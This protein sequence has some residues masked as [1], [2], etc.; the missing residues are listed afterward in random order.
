MNMIRKGQVCEVIKGDSISQR[1]LSPPR[2]AIHAIFI[3]H[4]LL[5]L[6]TVEI[7]TDLT[8]L[9]LYFNQINTLNAYICYHLKVGVCSE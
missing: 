2:S 3:Y 6:S 5:H 9:P 4:R 8:F 7:L 1:E